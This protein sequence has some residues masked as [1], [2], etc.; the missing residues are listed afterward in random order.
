MKKILI[1]GANSYI[2]TSFESFMKQ[3]INEYQIDTVDM[4]DGTW[5][6]LNFGGYDAVFHVAGLAHKTKTEANKNDYFEINC[7]LAV[8]TAKKAKM[9]HVCQFIFLSTMSV[10]GMDTGTISKDTIPRPSSNYGKSKK[11][12]EDII[13][14]LGSENFK[15][16]IVRPPMVYGKEC[17]GN[18]QSIVK[19]VRM[20]PIFPKVHNSRSMLFIDNLS[21]F[22]KILVDRGAN[23]LFFPQ[24]RDYTDTSHMAELIA[25]SLRKNLYFSISAGLCIRFLRLF[26]PVA[27]KA[28]GSLVYEGVEEF[29][30]VYNV[31]DLDSSI[32]R[33]VSS[34]E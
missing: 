20:S 16:A 29:D 18:F 32:L 13:R 8:E 10:Y 21:A 26:L 1:T 6:T 12:A 30:F 7:N 5:R 24:N 11:K 23:G 15:V 34:Q 22:V 33:S 25:R 2:G 19:L 31:I 9:D 3:W 27:K 14:D 17:K 28:F 4:I